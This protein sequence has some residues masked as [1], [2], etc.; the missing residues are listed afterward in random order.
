M[1]KKTN[2]RFANFS[3]LF[4][5]L[6]LLLCVFGTVFRGSTFLQVDGEEQKEFTVLARTDPIDARVAESISKGEGLYTDK[7]ELFGTMLDVAIEGARVALPFEGDFIV[8][9]WP[10]ADR[11]CLVVSVS[12][13]GTHSGDAVLRQ[14]RSLLSVGQAITLFGERSQL[15]LRILQIVPSIS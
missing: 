4:L 13:F 8:G 6:L 10:R 11:C 2:S 12:I 1:S 14:G 9:E 15:Q 3:D 7:G 5:I